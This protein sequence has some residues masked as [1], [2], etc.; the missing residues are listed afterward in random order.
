MGLV[1]EGDHIELQT[2]DRGTAASV[3]TTQIKEYQ[4]HGDCGSVKAGQLPYF[5]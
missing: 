2:T 4:K 5:I 3:Q 1:A